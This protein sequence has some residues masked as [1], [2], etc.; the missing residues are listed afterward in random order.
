VSNYLLPSAFDPEGLAPYDR[1]E[2]LTERN[3][4]LPGGYVI[5]RDISTG[6]V[7]NVFA[8]RRP[9]VFAG[10]RADSVLAEKM[11]KPRSRLRRRLLG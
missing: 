8:A 3:G 10:P 4:M 11:A 5:V 1:L 6:K 2:L 9:R 7:G